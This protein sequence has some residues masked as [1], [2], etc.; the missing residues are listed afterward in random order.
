MID[1]LTYLLTYLLLLTVCP[2]GDA[3][4]LSSSG[5]PSRDYLPQLCC[6]TLTVFFFTI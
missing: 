4:R 6:I 2:N 1:L 3:S 5:V